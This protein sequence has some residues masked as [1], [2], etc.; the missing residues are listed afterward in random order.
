ME[1]CPADGK[2]CLTS[3]QDRTIRLWNPVRRDPATSLYAKKS[4]PPSIPH[5]LPIQV[6]R[7]G[8]TH[9]ISAISVDDK[10][11]TIVSSSEK[12]LVVTDAISKKLKRRFHGHTG[13]INAVECSSGAETFLSG[14]Y[15]GTVRIWD[16]RSWS[17]D[18]IQILSDAKDS[19]SSLKV[20]QTDT[21][22][23]IIT[24][25]IDG[26]IRT[27]DLR[28]GMLRCDDFGSQA[29]VTSLALTSDN[30][31]LAAASLDG[32]IHVLE[33]STGQIMQS[34][35]STPQKSD[36]KYAIHCDIS[37]DNFYMLYG[38]EK[39]DATLFDLVGGTQQQT[40]HGHNRP[41]CSVAC[42]PQKDLTSIVLT[43]SYDG[44]GIV[45]ANPKD[46]AKWET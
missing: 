21:L 13:R 23:E 45:W 10:S 16:G 35:S 33:R 44:R 2:Y 43:A 4:S 9:P 40:L 15:D 28:K 42:H 5:A 38:S 20:I 11:T 36:R 29:A 18:P 8:H 30:L 3:G 34:I 12:T 19:V 1:F 31:C 22:S 27:Y 26:T 17:N 24:A 32:N 39:G 37:A 14:S 41:T 7:D 46:I 6:Y 25:S